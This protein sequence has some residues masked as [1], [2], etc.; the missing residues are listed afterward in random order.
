M[1]R[2]HVTLVVALLN[3]RF[4]ARLAAER[5]P[6]RTVRR[7]LVVGAHVHLH[8]NVVVKTQQHRNKH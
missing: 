4:V 6:R 5:V 8:Y 7:A 3:E 2:E 1:H